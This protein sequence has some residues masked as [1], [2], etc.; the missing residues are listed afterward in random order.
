MFISREEIERRK[1]EANERVQPIIG[2]EFLYYHVVGKPDHPTVD[3]GICGSYVVIVGFRYADDENSPYHVDLAVPTQTEDVFVLLENVKVESAHAM[4]EGEQK[5][6]FVEYEHREWVQKA[7]N[8][9][10]ASLNPTKKKPNHL[11]L[12][13]DNENTVESL[14]TSQAV[15]EESSKQLRS[16]Q[17]GVLRPELGIVKVLD[18]EHE[19]SAADILEL[20]RMS[21]GRAW[22][23]TSKLETYGQQQAPVYLKALDDGDFMRLMLGA[24]ESGLFK[25]DALRSKETWAVLP[26]EGYNILVGLEGLQ[27]LFGIHGGRR[28]R[29]WA[30]FGKKVNAKNLVRAINAL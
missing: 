17:P 9:W 15:F 21:V 19:M 2:E 28:A 1:A 6:V 14:L 29:E 26:M 8:A 27:V 11:S 18:E 12:V 4:L 5:V 24:N 3:Y 22:M 25:R 7:V 23:P 10:V 30:P 13:V 16:I 20:L